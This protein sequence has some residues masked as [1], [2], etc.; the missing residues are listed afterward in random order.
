M[1]ASFRINEHFEIHVIATTILFLVELIFFSIQT[2]LT[3]Q[4]VPK[5]ATKLTAYV[6]I[7]LMINIFI[8]S[9]I[10]GVT[11]Y[12]ALLKVNVPFS[13]IRNS[14]ALWNES[15]GGYHYHV[16][17]ARAE[18]ILCFVSS[19]FIGSFFID[20]NNVVVNFENQRKYF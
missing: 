3:C 12:L 16:F 17:S 10:F 11:F 13:N 20:F 15:W 1:K 8:L 18:N 9:I 7:I 6:R 14:S 19:L 2:W 4:L 5:F